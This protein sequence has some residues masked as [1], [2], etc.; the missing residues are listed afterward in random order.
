MVWHVPLAMLA[1]CSFFSCLVDS[2]VLGEAQRPPP[3]SDTLPHSSSAAHLLA[4]VQASA[5][6]AGTSLLQRTTTP[7]P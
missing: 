1:G 4:C 3:S 6:L 2:D 5:V 7:T